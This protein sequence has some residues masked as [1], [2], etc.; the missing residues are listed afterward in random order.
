MLALP[1]EF[2]TVTRSVCVPRARDEYAFGELH[3]NDQPPSIEQR[4][5]VTVPVVLQAKVALVEVVQLGGTLVSRTVGALPDVELLV[6]VQ[7]CDALALPA[8]FETVTRKV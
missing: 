1:Y 3:A 4:V 5:A 7:L 8:L 6:M 2:D